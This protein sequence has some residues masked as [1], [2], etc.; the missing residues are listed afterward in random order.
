MN[1]FAAE[2]GVPNQLE[3][4]WQIIQSGHC[5]QVDLARAN[6]HYFVQL[7]GVGLDAQIVEATS[8]KLKKSFGP[9]S[10]A[11]TAAKIAA[12]K[13][14]RLIVE[15]DGRRPQEAS[16]VLIGNGRFYGGPLT[17][18]KDARLDDQKLDVLMFKN[19]SYLDL[20]RYLGTVLMGR[21][22]DLPDVEYF[23]THKVHVH[24]EDPVPMEVDGEVVGRIPVT[25]RISSRKLRVLVPAIP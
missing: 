25:F 14:P 22:T 5:R 10:Y 20:A 16:F 2:L 6:D 1:V 15:S 9:L 8:W 21:H 12:Q 11:I 18:F 13:A 7:A 23:Q 19:L 3:K 24:S 17:F 4:A